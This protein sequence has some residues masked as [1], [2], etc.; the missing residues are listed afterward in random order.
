MMLAVFLIGNACA[1]EITYKMYPGNH[2]FIFQNPDKIVGDICDIIESRNWGN[3]RNIKLLFIIKEST[4][5]ISGYFLF[6]WNYERKLHYS[7]HL[8]LGTKKC[9]LKGYNKIDYGII[10]FK[11]SS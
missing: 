1:A 9:I 3:I 7:F 11:I 2:F 6:L 5:V 10:N 4:W 8:S